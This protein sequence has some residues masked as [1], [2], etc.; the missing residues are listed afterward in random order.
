MKKIICIA[1]LMLAL[2]TSS[3]MSKGAMGSAFGTTTT[4]KSLGAG[5]GNAGL[6]IGI[7]DATTFAGTF[8]YGMS[9]YIDGRFK[10]GMISDND[11]TEIIFGA[12]LKYQIWAMNDASAKPFDMGIGGMFE[13][14]KS[15]SVSVLLIGGFVLGS[16]P[17][18]LSNGNILTPYGRFN[19]RLE[20]FSIDG[21]GSESELEFGLNAGVSYDLSDN[22]T[23][24]G[25]FQFDGNNGIFFGLDFRVL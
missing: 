7:A 3:V 22:I 19:L 1:V 13:Y 18:Q 11:N 25:E 4:A 15:G 14:F 20:S 8:T 2:S 10:L 17:V 5:V 24:F 16:Y 12:D 21:G 9:Q 23:A 6:V